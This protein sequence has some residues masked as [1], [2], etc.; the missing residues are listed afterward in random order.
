[1]SNFTIEDIP[2]IA[3][4]PPAPQIAPETPEPPAA[5][6]TGIPQS[7]ANPL[8]DV[9]GEPDYRDDYQKAM[10]TWRQ[11]S[12]T[13]LDAAVLDPKSYADERIPGGW[14]PDEWRSTRIVDDWMRLHSDGEAPPIGPSREFTRALL[15]ERHFGGAG[16]ESDQALLAQ[17]VAQS[18]QRRD[19]RDVE[20]NLLEAAS[21]ATI[22]GGVGEKTTSFQA[23]RQ[24]A[25]QKPG[26]QAASEPDYFQAWHAVQR[27]EQER[28]EPFRDELAAVWQAMKGGGAGSPSTIL[29]SIG[30]DLLLGGG[31]DGQDTVDEFKKKDA[32]AVAFAAYEKL[33]DDE[34]ADFMVG[35]RALVKALPENERAAAI[36]NLA[37]SG[38]RM[39]DDLARNAGSRFSVKGIEESLNRQMAGSVGP[40]GASDM[41]KA[42][43]SANADRIEAD[44]LAQTNFVDAV[45]NIER[46]E[47]SPVRYFSSASKDVFSMRTLEEGVYGTP[48]VLAS[49][50]TVLIPGVGP[51]AMYL[52]MEGFAY[53]DLRDNLKREGMSEADASQ[54]ANR[55]KSAAAIPQTALEILQTYAP[56]GK[57]PAVNRVMAQIG[58]GIT[59]RLLRGVVK[60]GAFGAA[61]TIT[62]EGQFLTPYVVQEIGA[63]FQEAMPDSNWTGE[64]GAFDGFWT[65]QATVF[66]SMLPLAAGGAVGGLNREARARAF[67]EASPTQL[68]AF[69]LNND[70]IASLHEARVKGQSSLNST[71]DEV[72][73]NRTPN[74]P[75]AKAAAEEL[76]RQLEA[77]RSATEQLEQ[78]GYAMPRMVTRTDGMIAVFDSVTNEEIGAG[79]TL[80]DVQRIISLHTIAMDNLRA[81][82]VA[83]MAT[84]LLSGQILAEKSGVETVF[85]FKQEVTLEEAAARSP[86]L[87]ER[88]AEELRLL[89]EAGGSTAGITLVVLGEHTTELRN[90]IKQDVNYIYQGGNLATLLE[91]TVHGRWRAARAK[92]VV[93]R[94]ED[95]ALLRAFDQVLEK[96]FY[97]KSKKDAG[98]SVRFIPEGMLDADV[99]DA[100]IEEAIGQLAQ[101]EI[102]R[103][104][105]DGKNKFG[106]PRAV[107]S[108]HIGA[109]GQITGQGTAFK[110]KSFMEALRARMGIMMKRAASIKKAERDGTFDPAMLDAYLDKVLGLDAQVEHDAGVQ[111]EF[112]RILALPDVIDDDDIP[113]SIGPADDD[114]PFSIGRHNLKVDRGRRVLDE[115]HEMSQEEAKRVDT[116]AKDLAKKVAKALKNKKISGG[117]RKKLEQVQQMVGTPEGIEALK[118]R[119][120]L[121]KQRHSPD[122]GWFSPGFDKLDEDGAP[123]Y[124]TQPYTFSNNSNG[125]SLEQGS[126]EYQARVAAMGVRMRDEVRQ[127]Y[128]RAQAGDEAAQ[129]ILSQASWYKEIRT[130]LRR[131]FGGLGDLFA[132]LLGATSPNT[133]VRDNW[134]NAVDALKQATMGDFDALMPQWIQW[135]EKVAAAEQ[136]FE[137]WF[138]QA[139]LELNEKGKPVS[140]KSIFDRAE[141]KE[142]AESLSQLRKL[143][144]DLLPRK[145]GSGAKYGFN[146]GNVVRAMVDLWRVVTDANP[147]IKIGETAPK[148]INFSGNLIG[149]RKRATI[150]VWAARMLQRLAG[151]LRVASKAEGGVSGAMR[152]TGET[153]LQFGFGQDVFDEAS[154][155]IREDPIL[156]THEILANVQPDDLQAIVWFL[157][158]EVWTKNNWTSA[159][160][161]GGS[162]EFE[163][164][165][166]GV[167]NRGR[168]KELRKSADSGVQ[169]TQEEK[170][171][172]EAEIQSL[173]AER[174]AATAERKKEIDKKVSSLQRTLKKPLPEERT[175]NREQ[176]LAELDRMKVDPNYFTGGVTTQ[177]SAEFQGEDFIPSN[178][179]MAVLQERIHTAILEG[180]STAAVIAM[181]ASASEGRYG[182]PERAVDFEVVA[183]EGY[184]PGRL[185]E[186]LCRVGEEAN[187]DSVFL[188]RTLRSDED[189][190]PLQHRVSI[191]VF[192]QES[193][194]VE[195]LSPTLEKIAEMGLGMYTVIVDGRR[196]PSSIS[197]QMPKAVGIRFFALPEMSA[198]FGDTSWDGLS[199]QQIIAKQE[200]TRD[201][202]DDLATRI[203]R[204]I[205]IVS[206]AFTGYHEVNVSFRHE[207]A[208]NISN[209][210]SGAPSQEAGR[211]KWQGRSLR[212]GLEGATGGNEAGSGTQGEGGNLGESGAVSRGSAES[213]EGPALSIGPAQVADVMAGNALARITDPRRR[214]QVMSRIARDFNAMRL[215]IDRMATLSGF[216]R[217]K[218]DMRAEAMARQEL[219]AEELIA[220]VHRRFGEIMAD[221][222]LVKIKAQPVHAFLSDP[223]S[224]LRG[225]LKSKAAAI[226]EHPDMFQLHRAGDYDGSDGV[227]RSVFGGT[228]M[229]DQAAQEL[230]DNG[231]IPEPTADAM[232]E[233]L[234]SEQKTVAGMK[235]LLEKARVQIRE[236]KAQAKQEA[237]EWL[238][239]QGKDQEVNF[240]DKEEIRRSLRML[241]AILLALPPEI[242]GKIGGY[243]QMA[244]ITTDAARLAYLKD[245]LAKADKELETFLRIQY[246][247]E[248]EALLKKAAPAQNES[249][250]RPTGSIAADAY[251]IFRI[252]EAAMGMSFAVGEA[253]ADKW[254][255]IADHPDT[256]AK[257]ADIAR[258]NAQMI[259]LT[260]NWTA[261]DAA[262]REQAVLEGEK[263]YFDGLAALRK[264]ASRRRER[265]GQLRDSAIT[266]TGKSG[267]RMQREAAIRA[268]KGNKGREA[269]QMAW[270]FLSFGQVV[271][272]LFGE[273]SAAARW[274]NARELAASNAFEDAFQA[275]ANAIEALFVTLAGS[276]FQ[277]EVLKNK[278]TTDLTIKVK[279]A[280]GIEHE[281]S[282]SQAITFLLMWRQEDGQRHM[283]GL[284]DEETQQIISEWAWDDASAAA[285]EK[286]LSPAGHAAMAFLGQSYGEEYGRIN[287]VFRRIWNVSMPRHKMYSPLSVAP[288]Q[289]K[290]DTIMDPVS[291]DTMGAGMTPGSL[292]N[293]SFSAIAEPLFKD[294]FQVYVSHARQMEHF[295]AYG[296]F[297]RDS[298][299]IVNRREARNA[300][301][302]AGG[303]FAAGVLSKW[304]D[305]FAVG[306]V[307]DANMG[308]AVARTVGGAIGRLSQAALVGR[309]SV[310]AMQ[311]LQLVA[312]S[313]QM[314]VGAF[315]TRL[316]KL[317]FGRLAWGDAIRSEYI[318]RRIAIMPPIVRDAVQGLASGTPNRAKYYAAQLGKTIS[319][320]D[321]LFTGGTYAIFY[322]YHLKLAKASR[323]P[324]PEAH[325]HSEAERLTDQV[326]QPVRIG[327]RSWLEVANQG[328]PAFRAMWNFSSDPRQ[329][330]ALAVYAAMRRDTSAPEKTA[331]VGKALAI[332]WIG[333]GVL[334]ALLR[335]AMR[336]LRDDDDDEWF[337]ERHWSATR[338]GLMALTGP[339]GGMPYFG[340]IMENTSYKATGEYMP[341]GGMLAGIG[342]SI[343]LVPK[344]LDGDFDLLKDA[345]KILTDGAAASGTS[346]ALAS[347][348]HILRDGLGIIENLEGPD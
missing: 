69:G 26:Y 129:K 311:S 88:V 81:D 322:D 34:R 121:F 125:K 111:S 117:D 27:A 71:L 208:Q 105:K 145:S 267:S 219:R 24:E 97:K 15:A 167:A 245:K 3:P 348:M 116:E 144:D 290:A 305:F 74:S 87:A 175:A 177:T 45:R 139:R 316:A 215:Q 65:R 252:A 347:G 269:L 313:Y 259:R 319:G 156:S 270:E 29:K 261:A 63:V 173:R 201:E 235:E 308:G 28:I 174:S 109:V 230:Y 114:I 169:A 115:S 12:A 186:E 196:T 242:R 42:K 253:E 55:Y 265:L 199:D 304:L 202:L 283:R 140:K 84:L 134:D 198:R 225:R 25:M 78:L 334:A 99:S 241:D 342:Q 343:G 146:G 260:M 223:T 131:T 293:R 345:E 257:D 262:R 187:Q 39:V 122:H 161:E 43:A 9:F 247:A 341:A 36:A 301:E 119:I 32:G 302:A 207:H 95:I 58:D 205:P 272:V 154:R 232:W 200:V 346:A 171:A 172:A 127:V 86:K 85:G 273:A 264:E 176:A 5:P 51:S 61:E 237:N 101:M 94:A 124:K 23:W 137:Q 68:Q 203:K 318:Q 309:V 102:F 166:S 133:P 16:A 328:N 325:A 130:R 255:A 52:A 307:K 332:T 77:Q 266:G 4:A 76:A 226:R 136:E 49:V 339:L 240:S 297:S 331:A 299:A 329:K 40:F 118:S 183:K 281:F 164:D 323:I 93:T 294:A 153:T 231:L 317:K 239:T 181:K 292:K 33:D 126:E 204:E 330:V 216:R 147:D 67:A 337:D 227:S 271:N 21:T 135:A 291:G 178:G 50:G 150:D 110:F 310:L 275:K 120:N 249:G 184:D 44:R 10:D 218:S 211:S 179:D 13:A 324:N 6:V 66:I 160:G 222:D 80:E 57:I 83:K 212:S 1:M 2:K 106:L 250:Q 37:K 229:P 340:E 287:A 192:F 238:A 103:T 132:D 180:D 47:Y 89:E 17:V 107:V 303:P 312:A 344:W 92:G 296:E 213:V 320:A 233:A 91:E 30:A 195:E 155:L 335:A 79:K 75:E 11:E 70:Q 182:D 338:L 64:G 274:F 236:A 48:G 256:D 286:Q 284:V 193:A 188:A 333:S 285:I 96:S 224:P 100:R 73:P 149:F 168:I 306:G 112:D 217:S 157:E 142:R 254:D 151:F 138:A 108:A 8:F 104:A 60:A 336:D 82:E 243:T 189:F 53:R 98:K 152:S 326:A 18:T 258:V 162:F 221:D 31:A 220:D 246:A 159:A 185:F 62:E 56:M 22:V 289:G 279:D 190:D 248:W 35:L 263:I 315:L 143:G 7:T 170:D 228:R 148:A 234:M 251:D 197:G 209:R 300:I 158:K 206:S 46:N 19:G 20:M 191:S 327:A 72:L 41:D 210:R 14:T 128:D 321:A 268:A 214:T 298:L 277:G 314:P 59:N 244:M 194:S 113:F 280:L 163:M 288:A 165:L 295:I 282:D 38:G 278:M 123:V 141:Y 276:R 54:F 90:N